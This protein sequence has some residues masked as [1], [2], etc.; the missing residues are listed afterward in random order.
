MYDAMK[1]LLPLVGLLLSIHSFGQAISKRLQDAYQR[2]EN[3]SQLSNAVSSLYV[4]NSNSGDVVFDKN[5]RIGLPTA[6]TL[7]II[8]AAT[9]YELLGKNFRYETKFGYVGT[10]RHK[11]LFGNFYIKPSGDPTLGSWRW[12]TTSDSSILEKLV[13][14]IKKINILIYHDLI[15]DSRE[16]AS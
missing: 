3:D 11:S 6:S 13:S 8:T 12:K 10:I 2:F 15:I 1:K 4:I 5:S 14:E 9:A 16:W 7:K